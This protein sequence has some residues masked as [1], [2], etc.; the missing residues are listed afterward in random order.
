[1]PEALAAHPEGP[2]ISPTQIKRWR[3][4]RRSWVLRYICGYPEPQK[5]SQQLGSGVH[6]QLATYARTGTMP[7]DSKAGLV[8]RAGLQYL[9]QPSP[10]LVVERKSYVQIEPGLVL[11]GTLDLL[12]P[13]DQLVI[14]HKTTSGWRWLPS[15]EELLRDEQVLVYTQIARAL[16]Y[17]APSCRW[18]YYLTRGA[19]ESRFRAM[20]WGMLRGP[21]GEQWPALVADARAIRDA[22]ASKPG[23]EAVSC[24]PGHCDAYGGCHYVPLCAEMPR[25]HKEEKMGAIQERMAALKAGKGGG[26]APAGKQELPGLN[27]PPVSAAEAKAQLAAVQPTEPVKQEHLCKVCGKPEV[28]LPGGIWRCE[29]GH[30][31][32]AGTPAAATTADPAAAK[33]PATRRGRVAK[34]EA[35]AAPAATTADP[36][37]PHTNPAHQSAEP[38]GAQ[39]ATTPAPKATGLTLYQDCL[40]VVPAASPTPLA[41]WLAPLADQVAQQQGVGSYRLIEYG[42]GESLLALA[43]DKVLRDRATPLALY[44]ETYSAPK[45]VLEVLHRHAATIIRGV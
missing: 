21:L 33:P 22:W 2:A 37:E 29:L 20:P 4:C 8:A 24:N 42:K 31:E 11:Q 28:A 3:S 32:V 43:L 10:L 26:A 14:D 1:M 45:A 34:T 27:P 36:A 17:Q 16:G 7:D 35:P 18:V 23:P 38:Q 41:Q 25:E 40:P 13:T 6:E 39:Q 44:V 9:P 30:P 5:P 15:V 19:P 12:D